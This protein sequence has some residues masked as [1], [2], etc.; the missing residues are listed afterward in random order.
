MK[1]RDTLLREIQGK[2]I[3]SCQARPGWAMYGPEIMASFAAAAQ[4]GGAVAIRATG[5]DN[6][7]AIKERVDLPILAINK[8]FDEN[9]DVYITPT[10][11]SAKEILDLGV[12]IIALDATNRPRP[13][14]ETFA[15]I[16]TQIRRD[17]PDTLIMGEI[18]TFSEASEIMNMDIDLISTTLSGYTEAS[19]EVS[20][21]NLEL[22]RQI[23]H[24]THLPVIAEGKIET[25]EGARLALE[26]GAHAVVV[27]TS[28]T[29]PEVITKRYVDKINE[30]RGRK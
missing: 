24:Q 1:N 21:T 26:A 12:D 13:N 17:Y 6:I 23:S 10:F 15:G 16:V 11:A 2:L 5:K 28:I 9:Y 18:S 4:E 3:V 25:P 8:I 14:G 30:L 29:R 7:I 19:K 20:R 22:I 27:G